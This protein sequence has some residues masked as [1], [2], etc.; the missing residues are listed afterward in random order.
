MSS[1]TL[2]SRC[3][4]VTL[5]VVAMAHPARPAGAVVRPPWVFGEATGA[6]DG[7]SG[8]GFHGLAEDPS[9]EVVLYGGAVLGPGNGLADT[10]TW[11]GS[12]WSARCGA[13]GHAAPAAC[14]PGPRV[15]FGMS[16]GPGGV[17]LFGG[18]DA[19]IGVGQTGY[20][21]T[22][23]WDGD[24]WTR[25]CTTESCGP[26]TLLLPAMAGNGRR[27]VMFGGA[28]LGEGGPA[29]TD[30]T[31]VFDGASWRQ[32]CGSAIAD[33]CG[34]AARA[35][36]ALGWDGDEWVL[37]GGSD[38]VAPG[39]Q[40]L[41]D[42]WVFDGETWSVACGPGEPGGCGPAARAYASMATVRS[43]YPARR[44]ALLA[45]GAWFGDESTMHRDAWFWDGDA[46]TTIAVPWDDSPFV[47][48]GEDGPPPGSTGVVLSAAAPLASACGVILVGVDLEN[49]A[50]TRLGGWDPLASGA[51]GACV[52][53]AP[54]P[55]PEPSPEPEPPPEPGYRLVGAEGGVF[56]IGDTSFHGS[57][58]SMTLSAPVVDAA[59]TPSGEGYWLAGADGG[60]FAFGDATFHGSLAGADLTAPIVGLASTPS[61]EGYWLAGADGG[62]FA[63]GDA[64]F[65]GSA[66][67]DVLDAPATGIAPTPAGDGYWLSLAD[68]RV[69][70]LGDAEPLDG[71]DG[72]GPRGPVV[73]I[74]AGT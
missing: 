59:P 72:Y 12:H 58:G 20:G 34:P 46:W 27:V 36:A 52:D 37:F 3:W 70:P 31:W 49:G 30:D 47:A 39:A 62:V 45:G 14:G 55:P 48:Q 67:G 53:P 43:P 13:P 38:G 4:R 42:T 21:D 32:V 63:F 64:T 24:A 29:V 9:G 35:G 2:L 16:S 17:I 56:A 40:P 10:W 22:W 71:A 11:D 8:R 6:P 7:F 5:V 66:A 19:V 69:V 26:G 54:P 60:V 74:I 41:A 73:A 61:G 18:L 51:P 44:G 68:G 15:H 25:L 23:R 65:E 28:G 1:M 57:A 33:P 50:S